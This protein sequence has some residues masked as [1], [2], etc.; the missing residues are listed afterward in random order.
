MNLLERYF[1]NTIEESRREIEI[2]E[3]IKERL[4]MEAEFMHCSYM[5]IFRNM[6]EQ[7]LAQHEPGPAAHEE[8][9]WR[10]GTRNGLLIVKRHLDEMA[11]R[12][13]GT[14]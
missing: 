6:V 4:A 11:S 8:M 10:G 12:M 5:P 2:A 9:L 3:A 7:W 13:E 1:G 14:Q